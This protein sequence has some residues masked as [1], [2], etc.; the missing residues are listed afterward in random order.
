M[1]EVDSDD[2][3]QNFKKGM[4]PDAFLN[5]CVSNAALLFLF[6]TIFF[7]ENDILKM[8][9]F[10]FLWVVDFIFFLKLQAEL[11]KLWK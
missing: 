10:F 1:M 4:L 9:I 11:V 3:N 7:L 2:N 5:Y 8:I 6:P